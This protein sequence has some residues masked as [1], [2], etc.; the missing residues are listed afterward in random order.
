MQ[1]RKL[2][3]LLKP[4]EIRF[5]ALTLTQHKTSHHTILK[6]F[7]LVKMLGLNKHLYF[8]FTHD[9]KQGQGRF[10][11]LVFYMIQQQDNYLNKTLMK[12]K[13]TRKRKQNTTKD[14]QNGAWVRNQCNLPW[15]NIS[16]IG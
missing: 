11:N 3:L 1:T 5:A 14:Q 6:M 13:K 4:N 15:R 2:E 12:E 10:F 7:R 9:R 16:D 8:Q